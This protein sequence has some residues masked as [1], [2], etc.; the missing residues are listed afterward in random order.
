MGGSLAGLYMRRPWSLGKSW[1]KTSLRKVG[2][3]TSRDG[4]G[5]RASPGGVQTSMRRLQA[6][7]RLVEAQRLARKTLN[8]SVYLHIL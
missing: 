6:G 4:L 3:I 5:S 7:R 8:N 2:M 1:S